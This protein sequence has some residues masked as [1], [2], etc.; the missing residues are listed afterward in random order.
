MPRFEH[1]ER[2]GIDV[3]TA[4]Q[5]PALF[6]PIGYNREPNDGMKHYRRYFT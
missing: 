6:M 2:L 4:I 3:E 1:D 5:D